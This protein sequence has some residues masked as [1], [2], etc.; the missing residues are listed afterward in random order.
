MWQKSIAKSELADCQQ[1]HAVVSTHLVG[2]RTGVRV[3]AD[4]RPDATFT[5]AEPN[6]EDVY[7]VTISGLLDRRH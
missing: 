4:A 2:G 6:L 7:F 3:L 1:Q 5:P